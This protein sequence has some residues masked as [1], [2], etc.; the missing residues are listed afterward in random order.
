MSDLRLKFGVIINKDGLP[1]KDLEKYC[2]EKGIEILSRIPF[3]KE[4]AKKYSRGELLRDLEK[5][6]K[7][8]FE[9]IS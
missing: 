7:D 6:F 8:L 2:R 4:I 3:S 1:F 5:T 9:A